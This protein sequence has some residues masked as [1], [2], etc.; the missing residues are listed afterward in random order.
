[1]EDAE[2]LFYESAQLIFRAR[3]APTPA[4]QAALYAKGHDMLHRVLRLDPSIKEAQFFLGGMYH[5]GQGVQQDF[6]QA[7]SWYREAAK[8]CSRTLSRQQD[9][10]Q[11]DQGC[12]PAQTSLGKMYHKGEG[13][14]QDFKQAAAW[15]RKAAE[16]EDKGAQYHLGVMYN[17]GE[18]VQQDFEQAAAWYRKAAEQGFPA[19]QYNLGLM[20]NDGEGVQQDFKQ[21]VAWL[22]KAAEQGYAGAQCSLGKMYHKGEGVQQDFEQAAAW[23]RKAAEQGAVEA[24]YVL[25]IMYRQGQEV[26]QDFKQ[27]ALWWQ[28][29]ALQGKTRA[30]IGLG[31]LSEMAGDYQAAFES[32]RA[33]QAAD[34]QSYD[35]ARTRM[36]I[37][38]EKMA[39]SRKKDQDVVPARR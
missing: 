16:Q 28:K 19:A 15:Y 4:Q 29:A 34:S 27:A 8:E 23:H 31:E 22:R 25:G 39:E 30:Y 24:Q 33:G 6:K 5:D 36:R 21:A 9:Y 37:C 1:M 11:V 38:L 18:G 7:A 20:Y 2:E 10:K 12:A 32:Y 26:K 17:D 14:Q 35:V 3:K 13:V